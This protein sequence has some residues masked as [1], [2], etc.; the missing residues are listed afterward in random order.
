MCTLLQRVAGYHTISQEALQTWDAVDLLPVQSLYLDVLLRETCP[1]ML[2][3]DYTAVAAAAESVL[4]RPGAVLARGSGNDA[5]M[6]QQPELDHLATE[7]QLV[8][9]KAQV[10]L[11]DLLQQQHSYEPQ[12]MASKTTEH[13]EVDQ[14]TDKHCLHS[15][16]A[17]KHVHNCSQPN[18]S[19]SREAKHRKRRKAAHRAAA[20]VEGPAAVASTQPVL[21]TPLMQKV[22]QQQLAQQAEITRQDQQVQQLAASQGACLVDVRDW[23]LAGLV[24][25]LRKD[26]RAVVDICR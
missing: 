10:A 11:Q 23:L 5:D 19:P 24:T 26:C 16:S 4:S 8:F 25:L 13:A 21:L 17:P 1:I 6:S 20:I 12:E 15:A 2:Q 18:I 9:S 3:G 7:Q 22:E 14:Q